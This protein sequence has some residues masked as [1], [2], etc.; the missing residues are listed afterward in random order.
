MGFVGSQKQSLESRL[1]MRSQ[2]QP[3]WGK[4]GVGCVA[5]GE[6]R[7]RGRRAGGGQEEGGERGE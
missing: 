2:C 1:G 6:A 5:V 3:V 7:V 4:N